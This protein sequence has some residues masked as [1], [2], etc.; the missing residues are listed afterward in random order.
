MDTFYH[1]VLQ[2]SVLTRV[3]VAAMHILWGIG[4]VL[5]AHITVI[6]IVIVITTI[7]MYVRMCVDC[8]L[9]LFKLMLFVIC[10]R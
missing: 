7:V 9:S 3:C 1:A 6:T 4:D 10:C 5:K 8:L 2:F